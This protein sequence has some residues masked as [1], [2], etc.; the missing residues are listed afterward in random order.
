VG[1]LCQAR[2]DCWDVEWCVVGQQDVSV[3]GAELG[4]VGFGDGFFLPDAGSFQ[5]LV[6]S[7]RW[8]MSIEFPPPRMASDLPDSSVVRCPRGRWAMFGVTQRRPS[9]EAGMLYNIVIFSRLP[10]SQW[11]V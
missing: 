4:E 11:R 6:P 2:F 9:S 10:S 5:T 8:W 1:R 7:R 3:F